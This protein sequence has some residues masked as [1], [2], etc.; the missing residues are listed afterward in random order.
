MLNAESSYVWILR[1]I[2]LI[3]GLTNI[4]LSERDMERK[5]QENARRRARQSGQRSA[6]PPSH[7]HSSTFNNENGSVSGYSVLG[8][9]ERAEIE[10]DPDADDRSSGDAGRDRSLC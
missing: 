4:P 8:A 5:R 7:G 3:I 6:V 1:V 9:E 2:S 10:A